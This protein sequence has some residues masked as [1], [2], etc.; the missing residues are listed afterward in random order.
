MSWSLVIEDFDCSRLIRRI[1]L[2]VTARIQAET[3]L[4]L[5]EKSHARL[6]AWAGIDTLQDVLVCNG[7]DNDVRTHLPYVLP[8]KLELSARYFT[9]E[10]IRERLDKVYTVLKKG[11]K[12]TRNACGTDDAYYGDLHSRTYE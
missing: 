7:Y 4:D 12:Q 9:P 1:L 11:P 5:G 10:E 8:D 2:Q 3:S 6:S